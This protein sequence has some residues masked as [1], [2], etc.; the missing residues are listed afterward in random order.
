MSARDQL[1][2]VD[3]AKKRFFSPIPFAPPSPLLS[4][5]NRCNRT[6]YYAATPYIAVAVP[7]TAD[8]APY[9]LRLCVSSEAFTLGWR[10]LGGQGL[11]R[12]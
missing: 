9:I 2:I 1:C 11:S 4:K 7:Y 10:Y 3:C 12:F 6:R 5:R 8:N